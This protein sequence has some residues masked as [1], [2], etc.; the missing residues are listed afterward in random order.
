[1]D[2]I[3]LAGGKGTRLKD[4]YDGPKPMA[5]LVDRPFLEFVIQHLI[6][7][8]MERIILSVGYLY[9]EILAYFGDG[10]KFGVRIEYA[11]EYEPLGTAGG[12]RNAL[13]KAQTDIVLV[14][15]GDTLCDFSLQDLFDVH[16]KGNKPITVLH[17]AAGTGVGVYMLDVA[18][19]ERLLQGDFSFEHDTLPRVDYCKA[20]T[21][22]PFLDIG[23]PER[24]EAAEDI[25]RGRLRIRQH[26]VESRTDIG[27]MLR[28]QFGSILAAGE[29][30][31]EALQRGNKLL[32]CGNGGSAELCFHLVTE[33][34]GRFEILRRPL[35]AQV[36]GTDFSFLTAYSN[37]YSF[38]DVFSHQL[39]AY[40]DGGD[41]LVAISTSGN[42][43]NVLN[44]VDVAKEMR[45][46]T[47]GFT[48]AFKGKLRDRCDLVV[49]VPDNRT[50]RIQEVHLIVGHAL[51][52]MIEQRLFG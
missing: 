14:V 8:G 28:T 4:A 36:L 32:F 45:I 25:L 29:I 35:R 46:K 34:T 41:V 20:T 13:R 19:A 52:D 26:F 12:I 7:Q 15:N 31:C 2:A 47:I 44:A 11:I 39:L 18:E 40:G 42:S 5:P 21:S 48:N 17:D 38:E 24:Y 37:D 6:D 22:F 33:L 49:A 9:S 43:E 16:Y 50:C 23:T 10:D 51:C 30:M 27:V 3:I 1:M